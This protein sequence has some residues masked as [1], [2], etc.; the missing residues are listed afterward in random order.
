M[1]KS[2]LTT[3]ELNRM[4]AGVCA[5]HVFCMCALSTLPTR[6]K[7]KL[8]GWHIYYIHTQ[9]Q[10]ALSFIARVRVV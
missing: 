3:I 2:I 7:I 4:C 6:D 8:L 9:N 10:K 5:G 1:L